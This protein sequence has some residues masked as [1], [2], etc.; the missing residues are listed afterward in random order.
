[1]RQSFFLLLLLFTA[2]ISSS[3]EQEKIEWEEG[4]KLTWADFKGTPKQGVAYEANTNSGISFSW[5]YSTESGQP[6]LRYE[7]VT[8]F[9]PQ[10]S[11]VKEHEEDEY[12]LGHEQLHFDIS[13]LHARKLRKAIDEY[14]TGRNI[15]RDLNRLYEG[16]EKDRVEMQKLFDAETVHST[17][18]EAEAGW[19]KFVKEELAKLSDYRD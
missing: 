3:Q 15:R 4:K 8:N 9:F 16:I 11:W 2:E 12:L 14:E 13:E 18:K 5:N 17:N 7:V 10:L 1:M 19:I 6:V